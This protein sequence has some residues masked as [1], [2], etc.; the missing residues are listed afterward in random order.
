MNRFSILIGKQVCRNTILF[1][2]YCMFLYFVCFKLYVNYIHQLSEHLCVTGERCR[3]MDPQ[4]RAFVPCLMWA[5]AVC[6][7]VFLTWRPSRWVPGA[8]DQAGSLSS[9]IPSF[10]LSPVTSGSWFPTVAL[11]NMFS[12]CLSSLLPTFSVHF[13]LLRT[14]P[15]FAAHLDEAA[16]SFSFRLIWCSLNYSGYLW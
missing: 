16:S 3:M 14:L 12:Y 8:G 11:R 1:L 5:P 10:L 6:A 4:S 7:L 13:C 2:S 9:G 15:S